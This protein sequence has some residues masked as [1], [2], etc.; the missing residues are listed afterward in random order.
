ME[1]NCLNCQRASIRIKLKPPS[2]T[3]PARNNKFIA[4]L[5]IDVLMKISTRSVLSN[6]HNKAHT[7]NINLS[8]L[9]NNL[10]NLNIVLP[11]DGFT[12]LLLYILCDDES[13]TWKMCRCELLLIFSSFYFCLLF[14]F[15]HKSRWEWKR[16][17]R[18]AHNTK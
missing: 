7:L 9:I 10:L 2:I 8:K 17:R 12:M 6:V 4:F 15:D 16:V 11:T 5:S 1:T 18:S 3:Q 14:S 13:L